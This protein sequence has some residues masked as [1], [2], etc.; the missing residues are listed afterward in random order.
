MA[1]QPTLS[2][3]TNFSSPDF[4]DI[5]R[6]T[7]ASYESELAEHRFREARL[8]AAL[9]HEEALLHKKDELIHQREILSLESDHRLLNGLQMIVSLLSLQ[10]RAEPNPDAALHLST[11]ANRV[12]AIARASATAF[13]RWRGRCHV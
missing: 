5:K 8:R 2:S 9:A 1:H 12:A 6:R 13:D 7:A 4:G 3:V 11:A 10:G